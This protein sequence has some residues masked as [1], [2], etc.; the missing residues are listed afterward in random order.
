MKLSPLVILDNFV[1]PVPDSSNSG[2]DSWI[3]GLAT[4]NTP[5]DN[6]NLCPCAALSNL[7]WTTAVT[8]AAVLAFLSSTHHV[9][10]DTTRC[11]ITI[12]VFTRG[13]VPDLDS[14]LSQ[15]I[16]LWSLLLDTAPTHHSSSLTSIQITACGQTHSANIL[17]VRYFLFKSYY[18]N[19]FVLK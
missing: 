17:H 6:T 10:H 3:M 2:V 19:I 12:G 7:H 9:V 18:G 14:D 8:T 5:A 13:V 11:C 4:T 15:L 1:N 16:W